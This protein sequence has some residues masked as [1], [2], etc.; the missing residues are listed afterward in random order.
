MKAATEIEGFA[1]MIA[2]IFRLVWAGVGNPWVEADCSWIVHGWFMDGS[3]MV[4]PWF[5]HGSPMV[6]GWSI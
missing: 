1:R 4:H 2:F 3:P 6:Q 5:T